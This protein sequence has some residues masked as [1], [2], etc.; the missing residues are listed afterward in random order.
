MKEELLKDIHE[1]MLE[2]LR[3]ELPFESWLERFDEIVAR[4]G[5][6]YRGGRG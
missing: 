6:R 4:H 2:G 1:A 5:W 3:G